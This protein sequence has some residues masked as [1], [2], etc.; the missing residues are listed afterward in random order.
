MR[1]G[2]RTK[3]TEW[4]SETLQFLD[5]L[6]LQHRNQY[7]M[8]PKYSKCVWVSSRLQH[9]EYNLSSTAPT[10]PEFSQRTPAGPLYFSD[11]PLGLGGGSGPTFYTLFAVGHPA[12]GL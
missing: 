8:T 12:R 6:A 11:L 9:L 10:F 3:A 7:R 1:P 2:E 5:P 4:Q